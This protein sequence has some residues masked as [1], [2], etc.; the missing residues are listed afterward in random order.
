G[1]EVVSLGHQKIFPAIVIVVEEAYAPP[2]V[3]HG[4]FGEAGNKTGVGKCSIVLIAVDSVALI[5]EIGNH[6]IR[7]AVVVVIGKIDA[8]TCIGPSVSVDGDLRRQPDFLK[9]AVALVVVKMLNHGIIREVE[10]DAS[11]MIV[12]GQSDAESLGRFCE[13]NFL[14]DLCEVAFAIVVINQWRDG[15]KSV[16][17]AVGAITLAMFTAPD[18]YEIPLQV[19]EDNQV[20]KAIV[21]QIDPGGAG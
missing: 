16:G 17:M 12:I 15:G 7:P 1:I 13:A 18:I 5:G 2:R 11:V 4:D 9:L 6:E 20:E 14:G 21:V 8:H 3:R 10:V 19:A